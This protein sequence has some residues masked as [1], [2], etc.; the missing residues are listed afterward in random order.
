MVVVLKVFSSLDNVLIEFVIAVPKS[1]SKY[2]YLVYFEFLEVPV[3]NCISSG[4]LSA[5]GYKGRLS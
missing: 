2:L 1:Y 4:N 5:L 3:K